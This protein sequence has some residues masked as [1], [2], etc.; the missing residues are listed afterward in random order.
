MKEDATNRDTSKLDAKLARVSELVKK[1][2][3]QIVYLENENFEFLSE[4]DSNTQKLTNLAELNEKKKQA[5]AEIV[6]LR[7]TIADLKAKASQAE[8]MCYSNDA[9][10]QKLH[11]AE[12]RITELESKIHTLS[13]VES[14]LAEAKS[15][16]GLLTQKIDSLSSENIRLAE[17][18]KNLGLIGKE[19]SYKNKL[20]YKSGEETAKL[21][22]LVAELHSKLYNADDK[23]DNLEH[24]NASLQEKISERDELNTM[25]AQELADL[26]ERN[27]SYINLNEANTRLNLELE[28]QKQI[29]GFK[30]RQA[31]ELQT[32]NESLLR[33]ISSE[34]EK[35]RELSQEI[36][37]L[38]HH[39]DEKTDAARNFADKYDEIAKS[40]SRLKLQNEENVY[41][42]AAL[43]SE[44]EKLLVNID[45][46]KATIRDRD[47][48]IIELKSEIK[49][50]DEIIERLQK[51]GIKTE[52]GGGEEALR[53]IIN[54]QKRD[55]ETKSDMLRDTEDSLQQKS[56]KLIEMKRSFE[57]Q[58]QQ[59]NNLRDELSRAQ[60]EL[61]VSSQ[62]D[63][64][65]QSL[66]KEIE[67]LSNSRTIMQIELDKTK[68]RNYD[69]ESL[70]KTR[71]EH[72]QIL[73]KQLN[74]VLTYREKEKRR[75]EALKD[76]IYSY[77]E[78]IDEILENKLN[79][80]LT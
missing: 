23:I 66:E 4:I 31:D 35:S 2:G 11:A 12:L 16:N 10:S 36:I 65:I 14:Q 78:K 56:L 38:K 61:G 1:A 77:I 47:E 20:L 30:E 76:K 68:E 3:E 9:L 64:R 41:S 13:E 43:Q 25:L 79:S 70:L 40:Y 45:S 17:S 29:L 21:K 15:A 74:D 18:E 44:L 58:Q 34:E 26:K 69:L 48:Q 75:N 73:E 50:R 6:S 80:N 67:S 39:V 49:S 7:D 71:Y 24:E 55:L 52:L 8:E 57:Q 22:S 63:K 42:H 5:D 59:I 46:L 51:A 27:A 28:A 37:Q 72:V 32:S 54:E 19:I 62:T 33:R 60:D 53:E